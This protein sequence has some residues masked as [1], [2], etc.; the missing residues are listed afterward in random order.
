MAAEVKPSN[1]DRD[2]PLHAPP[3]L[4]VL[5]YRSPPGPPVFR[6][7]KRATVIGGPH[8]AFA[9]VAGAVFMSC[10]DR[11]GMALTA[12]VVAMACVYVVVRT[13]GAKHLT[14][15]RR[16]QVILATFV[17]FVATVGVAVT[18]WGRAL[19]IDLHV[20]TPECRWWL[21]VLAT[22]IGWFLLARRKRP[23]AGAPPGFHLMA[24]AES[25]ERLESGSGQ[26]SADR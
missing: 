10:L 8:V 9:T 17:S 14:A 13:N 1:V 25:P 20:P 12:W 5:D 6:F 22:A 4:L 23:A 19:R 24:G 3:A 26:P 2:P 11:H 7:P 15:A 18:Y 21:A 16:V